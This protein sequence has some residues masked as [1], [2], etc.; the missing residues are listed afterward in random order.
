[1]PGIRMVD[2]AED[3][4]VLGLEW[5]NRKSVQVLLPGVSEVMEA[6]DSDAT[7]GVGPD[8]CED[9]V[10]AEFSVEQDDLLSMIGVEIA[11]MHITDIIH[12]DL[13][14]SNMMLCRGEKDLVLIDFGL[15]YY[16]LLV[17]DKVVDL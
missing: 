10:L 11:K 7:D 5:V 4:F 9:A 1:M 16:S 12:G 14:T 17:E 15:A 3:V 2:V 13:T 8:C 6:Q